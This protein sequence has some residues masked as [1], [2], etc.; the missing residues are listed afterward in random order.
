[1]P[2]THATHSSMVP[3]L[4][5]SDGRTAPQLGLGV[6][7]V[8]DDTVARVV[9]DAIGL[10]YRSIDTATIYGNERGIGQ[11]IRESALPRGQLFITTK[12]W[13]TSHG[14]DA[15]LLA[16]SESLAKL[17]LDYV[18]LYLIHWPVASSGEFIESW[19]A[20]I[21]LRQDGRVRSIGVCNFNPAHLVRL[22]EETGVRPVVNQIE[23]HPGFQQHEVSKFNATLDVV[24]ESWSPLGQGKVLTHPVVAAMA[25]KHQR[26][27]AQVVLRWHLDQ[28]F[29]V[30]PKTVHAERLRE[31]LAPFGFSLDDDDHAAIATLDNPQGR[32]GEDPELVGLPPPHA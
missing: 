22:I 27:P 28:G 18:D 21:K 19:R 31:N 4:R 32:L 15:T 13:N 29:M 8:P 14:Y 16:F 20:M 17:Q 1:M 24:T 9:R 30:I 2:D 6:W 5:L 3:L 7:Q 23:L 11:G 25:R 10:G 12:L 26:T